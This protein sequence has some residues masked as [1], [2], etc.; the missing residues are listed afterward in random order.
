MWN[1]LPT[2]LYTAEQV[3]QLDKD[4]IEKQPIDGYALMCKA[5]QAAWEECEQRWPAAETINV[6]CGTGNNAGDGYVLATLARKAGKTVRVTALA[7]PETLKGEAQQAAQDWLA[8]GGISEPFDPNRSPEID[9]VVVDALL[10][11]GLD[12]NVEGQWKQAI[13]WINERHGEQVL[14]LDIPSGLCANT[15]AVFG[16]AVRATVTITF[17][18]VKLG[19]STGYAADFRGD[20]VFADLGAAALSEAPAAEA[21]RLQMDDFRHWF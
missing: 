10:G 2:Q 8:A 7:D 19:L 1:S 16:D 5:A 12:R 17:V 4:I 13:C 9:D 14:A 20:L 6:F 11:T 21:E 3:R 15:G 18:G